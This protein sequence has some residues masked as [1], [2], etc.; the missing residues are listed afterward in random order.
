MIHGEIT[1]CAGVATVGV[2][3]LLDAIFALEDEDDR[4]EVMQKSS[5]LTSTRATAGVTSEVL[6]AGKLFFFSEESS[7]GLHLKL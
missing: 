2:D 5:M 7:H 3:Q 4:E 1:L 6:S